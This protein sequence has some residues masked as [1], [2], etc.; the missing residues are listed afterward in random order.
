MKLTLPLKIDG[1]EPERLDINPSAKTV[2]IGANGSGKTRFAHAVEKSLGD[3]AFMLSAIDGL[4]RV[5]APQPQE[6]GIDR[7]FMASA[8]PSADKDRQQLPLDRLLAMLMSDEL[9]NLLAYKFMEH[10]TDGSKLPVTRLDKLMEVWATVFPHSHVLIDNGRLLFS[11][12]NSKDKISQIRLSNGERAAL[13]YT[14][15]MLYAPERSVVIID[16]PEMFLHPS[17][18][19]SI[20]NTLETLRPDCMMMYVTHDLEFAASRTGSTTLWVRSCDTVTPAWDYM[21]LKP[22]DA[23]SDQMYMAILG[24][25]RPVLFIEGD[26]HSIDA[27][28]Y[29]LIFPDKS[30]R[31]LGS[32]NK[33]I[34]ATRT[35]NDL[36]ALHHMQANGIVDRDRRDEGEVAYLRRKNIMVPEVAEI[37]NLLL[38]PDVIRAVATACGKAPEKVVSSVRKSVVAMFKHDVRSQAMQHTRHRVKRTIEYRIDGRFNDITALEKHINGLLES[39]DPRGLYE[40]FCRDF[41]AYAQ[42]DDYEAILRV[43]NQKSMLPGCNVAG[44]CGLSGKEQYIDTIMTI[45]RSNGPGATAIR[46]AV[47]RALLIN[48][49]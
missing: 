40:K 49:K 41:H 42:T 3:R 7:L 16:S 8:V 18:I 30:V 38:L 20:W 23:I 47:R 22:Q 46:Q 33:V 44:L 34:E 27:R 19:Q 26:P 36:N 15:A 6:S 31:S 32:C 43:Y 24:E 1:T 14:A 9:V 39:I 48:E 12:E 35:F 25:R 29:P 17:T 4:Y 13:Y 5:S 37:E 21:V 2:I 10:A 11:P 28:L 45:L